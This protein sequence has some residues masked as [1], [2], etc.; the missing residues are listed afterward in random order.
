MASYIIGVTGTPGV[1]KSYFA[2]KL[3]KKTKWVVIEI[4]DVVKS[5]KTFSEVDENGALIAD[6]TALNKAV[7]KEINNIKGN[8]V[9]IVGHLLQELNIK[10]DAVV[11][12]RKDIPTLKSRLEK[13]GYPKNKIRENLISEALDYCGLNA[14]KKYKRVS[15]AETDKEIDALIKNISGG[16]LNFKFK[17]KNKMK[18]MLIFINKNKDIGI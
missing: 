1:G 5:R 4:N 10:L 2:K 17:E 6:I 15:E 3:A 18:D 14:A 9:I 13:R 8:G 7:K 12:L 11:V 16:N